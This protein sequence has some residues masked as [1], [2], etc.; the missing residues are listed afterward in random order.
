MVEVRITTEQLLDDLAHRR[1]W[2]TVEDKPSRIVASPSEEGERHARDE[3]VVAALAAGPRSKAQLQ[4]ELDLP[5][6]HARG[7]LWRLRRVGRVELE[8]RGRLCLW[9]LTS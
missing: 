8:R 2:W 1:T 4:V 3:A 6:D 7:S 9:C 5:P